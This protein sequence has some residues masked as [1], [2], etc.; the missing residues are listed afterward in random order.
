KKGKEKRG[1]VK[2]EQ[3]CNA[4]QRV[5]HGPLS[6]PGEFAVKAVFINESWS[7]LSQP[8]GMAPYYP[9]QPL[10]RSH[11]RA[12]TRKSIFRV[13]ITPL[14]GAHRTGRDLYQRADP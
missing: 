2:G 7:K 8:R 13:K 10:H 3:N 1:R 12:V 6:L 5:S 9:A 14:S 11:L 4:C